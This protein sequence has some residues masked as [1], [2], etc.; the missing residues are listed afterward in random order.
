MPIDI[1]DQ[2]RGGI[3]EVTVLYLYKKGSSCPLDQAISDMTGSQDGEEYFKRNV[4]YL[5][6][7]MG[8]IEIQNEQIRLKNCPVLERWAKNGGP[9]D[10]YFKVELLSKIV[11]SGNPYVGYFADM[12][13]ELFD[14]ELF[15]RSILETVMRKTRR[16]RGIPVS[17]GE[18]LSAKITYCIT[19]LKFFNMIHQVESN[20]VIFVPQKLLQTVI[21]LSLEDINKSSV[22]LYSELFEHIDNNY[23]PVLNRQEN[24]L[25]SAIH[26]TLNREEFLRLFNF[27][28]VP[29]GGRSLYLNNKEFNA[30]LLGG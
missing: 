19:F 4:I 7:A 16:N 12:L 2:P 28:N 17:E 27:A 23:L 25:L 6:E 15:E 26:K 14:R 30:I 8:F 9:F 20:Y 18:E 10:T 1:L 3:L 13:R 22:K 21:L 29:D 11:K 24:R 5:L